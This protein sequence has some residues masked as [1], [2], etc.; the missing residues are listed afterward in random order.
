[1]E[2]KMLKHISSKMLRR[3]ALMLAGVAL[4]LA[5]VHPAPASAAP[6]AVEA[7]E[8][9]VRYR[10]A[11]ID[12]ID[13]A[14][15]EAGRAD[16]P[17][18]LL[19]HG[20]PTSSHMFRN[21]IP[22]L[23]DRYRV[24]APDYPGFGQSAAPDRSEFKYTFDNFAKLV[25]GLTQKLGVSRYALYVMDY[26]APV[27][28][29]LA[30]KHPDRVTALIVQNGNAYTEGLQSFWEP[31]QKYWASG[32]NADREAIRWLTSLKATKWQY[33]HGVPDTSLVSPDTWTHDQALL[34]RP[35]NQEIQ[36]DL[37]YD[38]RTNVPLYPEWQAYFRKHKPA[39]LV[40]WGK[41]DQIF[42][43]EG[44]APYNRDLP[45]VELHLLDA[46]H[47]ALETNGPEMAR[48]IRDFLGRKVAV[49]KAEQ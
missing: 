13:I 17:A 18:I 6:P 28:F 29:R 44:A 2:L 11:S 10:S 39:T 26:G 35:G 23:A 4:P 1:M 45:E 9:Q 31:I 16:A 38:Y 42:V 7:A 49:E 36:L 8:T 22:A 15:R 19:L 46:G 24:I 37:F 3:S 20:F 5:L 47:F 43:A 12:G 41:N 21:L 25:D 14:Y 40:I 48:L 30:A 34:D 33:T 32:S 27:G